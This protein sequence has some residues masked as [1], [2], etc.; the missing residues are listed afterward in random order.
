MSGCLKLFEDSIDAFVAF[1]QNYFF[2]KVILRHE[3]TESKYIQ[4]VSE[5]VKFG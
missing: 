5:N 4:T 2:S 3:N 1:S